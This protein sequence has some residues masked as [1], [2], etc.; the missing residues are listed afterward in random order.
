VLLGKYFTKFK[1]IVMPSKHWETV[2]QPGRLEFSTPHKFLR[3]IHCSP[4]MFD[5]FLEISL[6]LVL[7]KGLHQCRTEFL[8]PSEHT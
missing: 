1:R 5:D 8:C 7:V 4:K 3:S 2:P 6:A